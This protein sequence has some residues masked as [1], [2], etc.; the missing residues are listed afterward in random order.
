MSVDRPGLGED[1][2]LYLKTALPVNDSAPLISDTHV[3]EGG[4]GV[5]ER[6]RLVTIFP[7][8]V[9]L[10]TLSVQSRESQGETSKRFSGSRTCLTALGCI[11]CIR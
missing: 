7:F 11:V 4:R 10:C 2:S 5:S 3:G 8:H 6:R 9:Q 1:I